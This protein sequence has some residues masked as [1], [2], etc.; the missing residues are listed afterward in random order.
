MMK[1]WLNTSWTCWW[2]NNTLF[3]IG[4][5]WVHIYRYLCTFFSY[6]LLL[7]VLIL[8]NCNIRNVLRHK[9]DKNRT[10]QSKVGH[11]ER[12]KSAWNLPDRILTSTKLNY[13]WPAKYVFLGIR[14]VNIILEHKSNSCWHWKSKEPIYVTTSQLISSRK[15]SR[16]LDTCLSK[17][18]Y[19]RNMFWCSANEMKP[20]YIVTLVSDWLHPDLF[21]PK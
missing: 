12:T 7:L 13:W 17:Q 6:S 16:P 14:C 10:I 3:L 8:W 21:S 2:R 15:W 9:Q 18:K 4:W 5:T 11:R 20:C 19:R 1:V